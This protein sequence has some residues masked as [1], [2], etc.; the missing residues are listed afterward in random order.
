[1]IGEYYTDV[2]RDWWEDVTWLYLPEEV[3][4]AVDVVALG[5]A[6]V[7]EVGVA[8]GALE[9]ARV[10]RAILNFE[11]ETVEDRLRATGAHRN[12]NYTTHKN[13]QYIDLAANV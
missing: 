6:L 10:P 3:V 1:M 5:E 9:T 12:R 8:V 13:R 11:D 7:A 4:F 2:G